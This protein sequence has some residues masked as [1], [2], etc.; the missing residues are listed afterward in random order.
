MKDLWPEDIYVRESQLRA[1]VTI[2]KEQASLLGKKTRNLVVGRVGRMAETEALHLGDT[3]G[4]RDSSFGYY[5]RLAAPALDGYQYTLFFIVHGIDLYPVRF[6]LDESIAQEIFHNP[7]YAPTAESEA[8]FTML[9]SKIFAA[10]KTRS[11]IQ[12]MLAQMEVQPA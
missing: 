1:P 10:S 4:Y 11:V 12:A 5:F 8:E 2:L 6:R 3:V 9:L 7:S